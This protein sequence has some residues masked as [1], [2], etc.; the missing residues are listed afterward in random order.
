[1]AH[2]LR[3]S[4]RNAEDSEA[5]RK[6]QEVEEPYQVMNLFFVT[7]RDWLD[8]FGKSPSRVPGSIL[9]KIQANFHQLIRARTGRVV[10]QYRLQLPELSPLVEAEGRPGWFAVPS[11]GFRYWLKGNGRKTRLIVLSGFR[12]VGRSGQRHV[13][14]ACGTRLLKEDFELVLNLNEDEVR[15][16]DAIRPPATQS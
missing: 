14:T 11:G 5:R 12:I 4:R 9:G 3:F 2:S 15:Q 6:N 10:D 8:R 16:E 7:L 13:V 1:M